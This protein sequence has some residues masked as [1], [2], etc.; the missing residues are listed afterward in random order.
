L[1]YVARLADEDGVGSDD[2]PDY[3]LKLVKNIPTRPLIRDSG[4]NIRQVVKII[5]SL[6][7]PR[8]VELLKYKKGEGSWPYQD[9]A[10]HKPVPPK[11]A[12]GEP[13]DPEYDPQWFPA[14]APDAQCFTEA[15]KHVTLRYTRSLIDVNCWKGCIRK[16]Y[17]IVFGVRWYPG[18]DICIKT[19]P[20][21]APLPE[22]S[23]SAW[24][25]TDEIDGH[26]VLLYICL[27]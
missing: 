8:E 11:D 16:G 10:P 18:F 7:V 22:T 21:E 20:Y 24:G 1:Y 17:P 13:R 3:F 2:P 19:K 6:G 15:Q 27:V 23:K 4:S 12:N 25:P 26:S 9:I 14:R 5:A